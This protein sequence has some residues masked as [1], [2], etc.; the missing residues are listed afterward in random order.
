MEAM[1]G[2]VVIPPPTHDGGLEHTAARFLHAETWLNMARSGEIILFPPQ[3][4]LLYLVN[5]Y[6]TTPTAD[7]AQPFSREEL[8]AQRKALQAFVK[9][10]DPP[11]G[12]KVMSPIVAVKSK[13]DGR[14]ILGLDKPGQELKGSNRRGDPDRVVLVDFGKEGPRNVEVRWRK[15]VLE[16]ERQAEAKL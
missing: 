6:L 3:F 4:F 13:K 2:E 1:S 5:Q 9:E 14:S 15:E 12:D 16:E 10:G 7:A 8:K 11:W